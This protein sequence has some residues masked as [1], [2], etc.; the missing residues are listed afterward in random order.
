MNNELKSKK[1]MN[2]KCKHVY[3]IVSFC[4]ARKTE[5]TQVQSESARY[6][7]KYF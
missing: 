2:A 7:I 1:D 6:E 4:A 5:E 3:V